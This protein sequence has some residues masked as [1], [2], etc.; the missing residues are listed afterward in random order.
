MSKLLSIED[1]AAELNVGA[2]AVN[3]LIARRVL[4]ATPIDKGAKTVAGSY[5]IVDSDLAD[6]VRRGAPD[7]K[8]PDHN[9]GWFSSIPEARLAGED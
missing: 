7:V 4:K 8:P 6:Y 1:A 5:R 9:D 2:L 3:R